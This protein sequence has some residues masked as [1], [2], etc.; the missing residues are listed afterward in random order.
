[1]LDKGLWEKADEPKAKK[2]KQTVLTFGA[3]NIEVCWNVPYLVCHFP[4]FKVQKLELQVGR[5][6]FATNNA[7]MVVENKEFLALMDMV[8]P[9]LK[10]P[11]RKKVGGKIL[12]SVYAQEWK[13]FVDSL[14]G[15]YVTAMG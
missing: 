14:D 4:F 6:V 10:L 2:H 15:R 8:R 3:T 7:F 11:N 12:Q 1:M 9:G 13:K 5:F